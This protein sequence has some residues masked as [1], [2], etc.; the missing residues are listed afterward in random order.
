M[1]NVP[2][3]TDIVEIKSIWVPR[4]DG[5]VVIRGLGYTRNRNLHGIVKKKL[6]DVSQMLELDADDRRPAEIQG[7]IEFSPQ[8]ILRL[9]TLVKTNT[10]W[11]HFCHTRS[12]Q[13]S[14]KTSEERERK[15]PLVCRGKFC[16]QY[17]NARA[18]RDNK[19]DHDRSYT[20][21]REAEADEGKRESDKALRF[22]WRGKTHRGGS[23]KPFASGQDQ[24][25]TFGDAFC[26][27]GGV[28][29]GAVMAGFKV[30]PRYLEPRAQL[31]LLAACVWCGQ[32]PC[33]L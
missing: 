31:T 2:K 16:V 11:P 3:K 30:S 4:S 33:C 8:D 26:S 28:S 9:R 6:N 27:A 10:M 22:N 20:R 17:R 23:Y 13:W 15:A 29:R 7:Q 5:S 24:Q 1:L 18:R 14:G 32:L 21:L 19:P 12:R 25:F